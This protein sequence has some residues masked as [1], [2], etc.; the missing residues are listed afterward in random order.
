[1]TPPTPGWSA[2]PAGRIGAAKKRASGGPGPLCGARRSVYLLSEQS[3]LRTDGTRRTAGGGHA[4]QQ[5]ACSAFFWSDADHAAETA[6]RP[7]RPTWRR[8]PWVQ[9]E[10]KGAGVAGESPALSGSQH[11]APAHQGCGRTNTEVLRTWDS[12]KLTTWRHVP[13]VDLFKTPATRRAAAAASSCSQNLRTLHPASLSLRSVSLSRSRFASI[14][15]RHQL[16]FVFGHVPCSGQPCQKHP[17][18]KTATLVRTNATSA[19]RRVP[20]SVRST[21]YRRPR[22]RR[23]A[24]NATSPGVSRRRVARMR[25]RTSGDDALGLV[26]FA[27][28]PFADVGRFFVIFGPFELDFIAP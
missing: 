13:S 22:A 8:P 16:A 9:D 1:M 28:S 17:S 11:S 18:T 24:R 27:G 7:R 4:P 2:H 21:R 14:F 3:G 20:G 25:R 5:G 19:R 23:A 15:A 10:L 6:C 12:T 26:V